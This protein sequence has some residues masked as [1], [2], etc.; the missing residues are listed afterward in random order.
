VETGHENYPIFSSVVQ[1]LN[2]YELVGDTEHAIVLDSNQ[3]H[4]NPDIDN[5]EFLELPGKI[6]NGHREKYPDF[7]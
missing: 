5:A 6:K 1:K 2:H 3:S 4:Q 7:F